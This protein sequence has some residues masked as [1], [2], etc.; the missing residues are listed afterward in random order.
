[1]AGCAFG[2]W[3]IGFGRGGLSRRWN[4]NSKEKRNCKHKR[5]DA[6]YPRGPTQAC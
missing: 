4:P 5:P 2:G 1:M 6:G 3:A